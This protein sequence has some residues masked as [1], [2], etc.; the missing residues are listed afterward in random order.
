MF[1]YITD[2]VQ[3]NFMPHGHCFLW[4][5]DIL[6]L[7]VVSDVVIGL[8]Y[9]SIPIVLVLFYMKREDLR[10][11]FVFIL[12]ALF[13][14]F[15]GATHFFEVWNIWND[16]YFIEGVVKA[17]CA[18]ISLAT[19]VV[20]WPVLT[21][22]LH[23]PSRSAL[24]AEVE[25][26]KNAEKLLREN[27]GMLEQRV[28]SRTEELS[29]LSTRLQQVNTDLEQLIYI[30][31]HDLKSPLVT[32]NGFSEQLQEQLADSDDEQMKQSV[33]YI[34]HAGQ[35]MASILNALLEYSRAGQ[36]TENWTV[37]DIEPALEEAVKTLARAL[38]AKNVQLKVLCE[39]CDLRMPRQR[40]LQLIENLLSN[41]IK[42]GVR[43]DGGK[44][45][46]TASREGEELEIVIADYGPGIPEEDHS[47]IFSPFWRSA[48]SE[49]GSG[50][51]L[52][53]VKKIIVDLMK[54]SI[55]VASTTE[56]GVGAR[57]VVRFPLE[58]EAEE[59]GAESAP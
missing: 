20:A 44:I 32:V 14:L 6:L 15:C 50:L 24:E 7:H 23:L 2:L 58:I 48:A 51:G 54:G 8:S 39:S 49:T 17:L 55:S 28:A 45:E 41:A 35:R 4:R 56:D 34:S 16:D 40:F 53:I 33:E 43:E 27:Q 36:V 46:I 22:A 13:I 26:R 9:F 47:Q 25:Q 1:D 21:R 52:A 29:S 18:I 5:T 42:Y 3:S 10:L 37:F 59:R 57:F 11:P 19:A 12:S 31:S 38:Q 30:V